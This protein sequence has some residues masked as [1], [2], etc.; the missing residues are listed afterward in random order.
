MDTRTN[1]TVPDQPEYTLQLSQDLIDLATK[2]KTQGT[3]KRYHIRVPLCIDPPTR[4]KSAGLSRA[5][6]AKLVSDL[7]SLEM[8]YTIYLVPNDEKAYADFLLLHRETI[9]LIKQND[10]DLDLEAY[11]AS[12]EENKKVVSEEEMEGKKIVLVQ[13]WRQTP[14][15]KDAEAQYFNLRNGKRREAVE[16][17]LEQD[18]NKRLKLHPNEDPEDIKSHYIAETTDYVS[19]LKRNGNNTDPHNILLYPNGKPQVLVNADLNAGEMN[20]VS[21]SL[22]S[23]KYSI[24]TNKKNGKSPTSNKKANNTT[25]MLNALMTEQQIEWATESAARLMEKGLLDKK[26]LV[27]FVAGFYKEVNSYG[28][29][30]VR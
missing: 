23:Y 22:A 21:G 14:N 16:T 29:H 5:Q 12:G 17:L 10:E 30:V 18:T 25:S 27:G 15:W 19:W 2:A 1:L 3:S 4:N 11:K 13:K 8:P 26:D 7:N 6:F 9:A 28:Q 24:I 20:R